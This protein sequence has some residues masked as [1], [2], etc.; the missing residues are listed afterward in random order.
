MQGGIGVN[1]PLL[2]LRIRGGFLSPKKDENLQETDIFV[3]R[4]NGNSCE[5]DDSKTSVPSVGR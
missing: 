2:I 3:C 1:I 5:F 4:S